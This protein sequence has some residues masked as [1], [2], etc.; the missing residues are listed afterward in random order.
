MTR[1]LVNWPALLLPLVA[2][3]TVGL[4]GTPVP[5][6]LVILAL[7]L[8]L[9]APAEG[10]K[11]AHFALFAYGAYGLFKLHSLL[12]YESQGVRYGLV[13]ASRGV[14]A[15]PGGYQL[16]ARMSGFAPMLAE[17]VGFMVLG[18]CVLGVTG[19]PGGRA[20]RR[21]VAQLRGGDGQPTTVPPLLLFPVIFLWEELFSEHL[22]FAG[23]AA[24]GVLAAAIFAVGAA[25]IVRLPQVAAV[26]AVVGTV[27]LGL[28]G[29]SW[30]VHWLTTYGNAYSG[31]MDSPQFGAVLLDGAR[32]ELVAGLQGLT[33]LGF[34][35]FLVPRLLT[36]DADAAL[37][38]RAQALTRRVTRLTET[39]SDATDTAVAE[40]RRIERD[41]H[42]GAQARLVAVGMS[43]R[44]AEELMRANPEAARA[45]I[46]EARETSS[47]ALDDLR[48]LVRGIYPPV[49]ADRGLADAV[50]TLALDAPLLVE[51]DITLDEEPPTPVAAAVYFAIAEALTNA[52]RHSG[53]DAVEIGIGHSDGIL[54]ATIVDDGQ[55]GA[56]PSA[57]TGLS[58]IER[59]LATFDGIVAVSSPAGGPT[60]VVIEV[61]CTLTQG[62]AWS[63]DASWIDVVRSSWQTGTLI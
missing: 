10:A 50:R 48:G 62:A 47:R 33:L 38:A 31:A 53:A 49:L 51:T 45:L 41:L 17:A 60:I 18:V 5:Q 21:A 19:A 37:A 63:G 28:Y 30:G 23:T 25:L 44:A 7:L 46:A 24:P 39:R 58:G 34:G 57:G 26:L 59:R 27:I 1:Y 6:I 14:I 55:G 29:V 54:R 56:D 61:P 12:I 15:I 32:S 43:L 20:V 11:I 22:W 35:G 4:L 52:V 16:T 3:G 8:A 36:W 2:L 40:L 9:A 13:T 42:D